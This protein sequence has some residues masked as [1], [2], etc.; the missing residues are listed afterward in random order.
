MDISHDVVVIIGSANQPRTVKNPWTYSERK[1]MIQDAMFSEYKIDYYH[2]RLHFESNIDSPYNDDAWAVRVQNIVDKHLKRKR[3]GIDE[4]QKPRVGIIGYKKEGDASTFYLDYFPQWD[5]VNYEYQEEKLDATR[6]RELYFSTDSIR[7]LEGVLP[8]PTL[9]KLQAWQDSED[10]KRLVEEQAFMAKYKSQ[11]ASLPYAPTFVCADAVVIQSGHVLMVKRRA[12]PGKGQWALPGGFLD[13]AN[14]RSIQSCMIRELKEETK[15]KVPEKVLLG[16]IQDTKI[17]D[18]IGRSSRGRT[19]SHAY[20]IVLPVGPLPKV[21]GS[22]DAEL[23]KWV[24]LNEINPMN[25]F[26]D[27]YTIIS[28]FV[29]LE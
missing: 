23:A 28:H 2:P 13:A 21:R 22:D 9:I 6:V 25:C 19:I 8:Y 18:A 17:F 15:I 5:F 4:L 1:T 27:H 26:E 24:P 12:Y 7:F 20:K 16:N 14:D 11:F 10:Y 29:G 3:A